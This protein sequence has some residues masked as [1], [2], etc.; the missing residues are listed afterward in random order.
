MVLGVIQLLSLFLFPILG[1]VLLVFRVLD[2]FFEVSGSFG[3]S[4][5]CC[6][7]WMIFR[8]VLGSFRGQLD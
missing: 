1:L 8:D 3:E 5:R 7:F 2:D 4:V 6:I